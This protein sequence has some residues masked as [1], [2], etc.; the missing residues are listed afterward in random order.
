MCG[1]M[2]W[3]DLGFGDWVERVFFFGWRVFWV[4]GGVFSSFIF[5]FI[6]VVRGVVDIGWEVR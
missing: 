4:L 6:F 1:G 2:G 5:Y 3:D